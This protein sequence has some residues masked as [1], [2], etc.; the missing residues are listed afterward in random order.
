MWHK[1]PRAVEKPSPQ[2]SH[3][4]RP[5]APWLISRCLTSEDSLPYFNPHFPHLCASADGT[6][7]VVDVSGAI[8]SLVAAEAKARRETPRSDK[9]PCTS[10]LCLVNL[11]RVQRS[12]E[13]TGHK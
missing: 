6:A 4:L 11:R 5:K 1:R 10:L 7:D 2:M 3:T 9:D 13:H 12:R 8:P